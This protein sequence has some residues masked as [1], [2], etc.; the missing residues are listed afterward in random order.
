MTLADIHDACGPACRQCGSTRD[1][2]VRLVRDG[3]DHICECCQVELVV[4]L[5]EL[6]LAGL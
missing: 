3:A 6:V 4:E 1:D 2:G 5:V